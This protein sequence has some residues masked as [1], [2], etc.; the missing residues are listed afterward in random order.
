MKIN[1]N[2][3][4]N[5]KEEWDPFGEEIEPNGEDIII[6]IIINILISFELKYIFESDIQGNFDGDYDVI[7]SG[8]KNNWTLHF[9]Y[10]Q[11]K[12]FILAL[13]EFASDYFRFRFSLDRENENYKYL[14]H[15]FI[16]YEN[17][18]DQFD[19]RANHINEQ[20]EEYEDEW[21]EKDCLF[22]KNIVLKL[23]DE[24]FGEK[25]YIGRF[26]DMR[27]SYREGYLVLY[28][29]EDNRYVLY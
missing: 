16:S 4:L 11:R 18:D 23:L 9:D 10:D 15:L 5:E 3:F 6:N 29:E 7:I 2:D 12:D 1:F 22:D 21:W 14:L 19:N 24:F 13:K 27:K 26:E 8:T 25:Y 17:F 28:T 20:I